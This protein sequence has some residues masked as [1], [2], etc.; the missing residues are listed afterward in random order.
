MGECRY[1]CPPNYTDK[2]L[3]SELVLPPENPCMKC[4]EQCLRECP[5]TE[6]DSLATSD[7]LRG[8]QII[9]GDIYIRLQSGV[10]DTMEILERNLGDIGEIKGKLK[11]YRSPAIR[12]LS[13]LRSL[14][15]IHGQGPEN[16][17]FSL[18][19]M[20]NENLQ[21]LWDFREKISLNLLKGNLLVHFNS[22]LCLKEIHDLQQLLK[23]NVSRDLVSTESN[24]Y[25]EICLARDIRTSFEVLSNSSAEIK[26]QRINVS[27]SEKVIAY[28]IYYIEAPEKNITHLGIDTCV[29]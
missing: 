28:I 24:G 17:N 14:H 16:E 27:D 2:N 22:K 23:T 11:V 29:Q 7:L 8:C 9:N 26:W 3:T 25:E 15:T 19:I 12:S 5:G 6:V 13:F 4:A 20:S 21:R 10:A 1:T 18:V